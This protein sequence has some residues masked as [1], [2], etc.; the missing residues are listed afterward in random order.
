M[1]TKIIHIRVS[2]DIFNTYSSMSSTQKQ[3][4]KTKLA[5][6]VE[7]VN[8]KTSAVYTNKDTVYTASKTVYTKPQTVYTD[9][10]RDKIITSK[11]N[12]I[13]RDFDVEKFCEELD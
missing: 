2:E 1:K 6:L 8:K 3:L 12:K 10:L 9:P 7:K 11:Q 13:E 5:E 4:I